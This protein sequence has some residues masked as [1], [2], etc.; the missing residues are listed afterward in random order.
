MRK[1]RYRRH[2]LLSARFGQ[3]A[4]LGERRCRR[5]RREVQH[6]PS[7]RTGLVPGEYTQR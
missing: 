3:L 1:G 4:S 7:Q 6:H 5:H 2:G